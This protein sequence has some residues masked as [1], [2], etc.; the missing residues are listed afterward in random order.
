MASVWP[1]DSASSAQSDAYCSSVN[2]GPEGGFAHGLNSCVSYLTWRG[3]GRPLV[4][5]AIRSV[6][7]GAGV[8]TMVNGSAAFRMR[9]TRSAGRS[10][11]TSSALWLEHQG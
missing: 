8:C 1:G 9:A 6:G 11:V 3:K 5:C 10:P 4:G 7:G 2:V